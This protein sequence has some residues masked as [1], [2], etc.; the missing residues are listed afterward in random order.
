MSF[1]FAVWLCPLTKGSWEGMRFP[2]DDQNLQLFL[3]N[4]PQHGNMVLQ[5]LKHASVVPS[6]GQIHCYLEGGKRKKILH[7][8]RNTA[9]ARKTTTCCIAGL[10]IFQGCTRA[11]QRF[12]TDHKNSCH[13]LEVVCVAVLLFG[14]STNTESCLSWRLKRL[15]RKHI[16]LVALYLVC[17]L[18]QKN[19]F[20]GEWKTQN[21]FLEAKYFP[22]TYG[23][24]LLTGRWNKL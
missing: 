6:S 14:R 15:K 21:S 19:A 18:R 7:Q 3:K 2:K 11:F 1:L 10:H 20:C 13:L 9:N 16:H 12:S 24:Y 23:K 8:N 17:I 22:N 4:E 5:Q